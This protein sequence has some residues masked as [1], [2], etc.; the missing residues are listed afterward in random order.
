MIISLIVV[1]LAVVACEPVEKDEAEV[2]EN[3][4]GQASRAEISTCFQD[5]E[6]R[7]GFMACYNADCR[8]GPRGERSACIDTC[9]AAQNEEEA[10]EEPEEGPAPVFREC[11]EADWVIGEW[12]PWA[13]GCGTVSRQ[14]PTRTLQECKGGFEPVGIERR[15]QQCD[16]GFNCMEGACILG[17]IDEDGSGIGER[18]TV[19][20]R[21]TGIFQSAPREL[22]IRSYGEQIEHTDSCFTGNIVVE[23]TCS[24]GQNGTIGVVLGFAGC[25][26][27][28]VCH[29]GACIEGC[30]DSDGGANP[31]DERG[32]IIAPQ[33]SVGSVSSRDYCV[34]EDTVQEGRCHENEN[35]VWD[36]YEID[37][38]A[39]T[40]CQEGA[41]Q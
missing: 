34:D 25:S 8:N 33:P 38:P 19:Q 13:D 20:G 36:L 18:S 12:E 26:P 37:C 30:Y 7:A 29:E 6:C 16:E 1:L 11:V 24:T 41:C 3:L 17:C 10:Q 39:G 27:G 2:I 9:L 14:R 31:R 5:Q 21:T 28:E 23:G 4:A 15:E 35:L 32:Y 22:E 40:V